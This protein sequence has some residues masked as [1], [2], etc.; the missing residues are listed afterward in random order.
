MQDLGVNAVRLYSVDPSKS[1][2]KFMCAASEAGI[3]VLVGMGAPCE[4]CAVQEA[5][6]PKCYPDEMFTRMQM[7]YNAF[8]VYD[9][10]L[11]F[12]VA[13]EPNLISIDGDNG[14]TVAPCVKAMIRDIRK[15]A[16]SCADKLRQVPIGVDVADIPPRDQ[17]I[18]YF[19]C[20]VDDD[21]N[22]RSEWIGFNPYVECD[23][24]THTKYTQSTGLVTLMKEYA[25]TGYSR[26][27]M[28]G[29]FGCNIG[30]NTIDGFENQRSFYDAKW[31]NEETGMTDEIVGGNVFEFTT[32]IMN[33]AGTKKLSKT[34]DAGKYGVGYFQ[35]DDCDN[36]KTECKFTPYPEYDNLKTAYTTTKNSTVTVDGY[37]PKRDK[38][39]S[40]P[41]TSKI[42]TDL[43][44]M[45]K[46]DT[47]SC[48]VAQPVCKGK[49]SNAFKKTTKATKLSDTK[50]P[51]NSAT[52]GTSPSASSGDKTSST[53]DK[54]SSA[55]GVHTAVGLAA[56]VV[57]AAVVA[58]LA[59]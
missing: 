23:P 26:P 9:N 8:A 59:M 43:P 31:M 35:P 7:I 12:S 1:H 53:S 20:A 49:K 14:E 47:L 25:D 39:L 34:K 41:A 16:S 24:T 36:D 17:W 46:V 28:F 11:T 33:L 52:D 57:S 58:V 19:D 27:L 48:S 45:P 6:P 38:I 5:S 56:S 15:Y 4:N 32:E 37:T 3:Y 30:A 2:D 44:S 42:K 18:Q 40:C 55:S 21:E 10:T 54:T 22:T 29:E 50:E 13:N 51:T